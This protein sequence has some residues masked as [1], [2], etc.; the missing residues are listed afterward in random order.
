MILALGLLCAFM[1]VVFLVGCFTRVN[2]PSF[3]ARTRGDET[4]IARLN[5]LQNAWDRLGK[6]KQFVASS[7]GYLIMASGLLLLWRDPALAKYWWV[8]PALYVVNL[9]A[10]LHVRRQA[11]STP[12]SQSVGG[13]EVLKVIRLN[14]RMCITFS[15]IFMVLAI[16]A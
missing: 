8:V 4:K 11:A 6:A 5:S 16:R 12:E 2:S 1:G 9:P 3:L 13:V 7:S 15:I 14:I 10:L